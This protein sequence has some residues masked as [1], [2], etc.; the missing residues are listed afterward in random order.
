MIVA[1]A[2]PLIALAK[3]RRLKLLR[4]LYGE[5]LIGSVVKAETIDAGKAIRAPGVEQLE[6]AL[7][8][9]WLRL[10][11]LT[12][13]EHGLMQRLTTRSRL[14]QGEAESL[15]LASARGLRLIVDDNEARSVASATGVS[16]LGTAGAL[17]EGYMRWCLGLEE[18]N[19][20]LGDLGRVLWLSPTVVAEV[21]RFARETKR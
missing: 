2:S 16:H 6:I 11:R 14:D 21:L 20:A 5:V 1:D 19:V 17:L 12:A 15:A 10:V 8:D 4:D 9:G 7:G 3:L 18:L 13:E